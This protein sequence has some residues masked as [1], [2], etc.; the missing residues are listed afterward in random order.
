VHYVENVEVGLPDRT[1][2]CSLWHDH[3]IFIP[4]AAI[5]KRPEAEG[6]KLFVPIAMMIT[7]PRLVIAYGLFRNERGTD[8]SS[9]GIGEL[10]ISARN[11]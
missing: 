2:G 6:E 1:A 7:A 10:G 5:Q 3:R 4:H 11:S 9:R 8:E